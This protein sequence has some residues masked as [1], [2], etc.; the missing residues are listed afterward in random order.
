[1]LPNLFVFPKREE[2]RHLLYASILHSFT[3][4]LVIQQGIEPVSFSLLPSDSQEYAV[5]A[6][7]YLLKAPEEELTARCLHE[8]WAK[9]LIAKGYVHGEVKCHVKR[10]HPCLVDFDQLSEIEKGKDE[11]WAHM[12]KVFRIVEKN[13]AE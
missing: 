1:M 2:S 11:I 6:V 9:P 13:Y 7:K 5:E 12:I 4:H 10:T 3:S 8:V